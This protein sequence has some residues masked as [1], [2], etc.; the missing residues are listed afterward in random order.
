MTLIQDFKAMCLHEVPKLHQNIWSNLYCLA[1]DMWQLKINV[2]T[3]S[4]FLELG[5]RP[6]RVNLSEIIQFEL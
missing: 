3:H 5:E 2:M 6:L 4:A 1:R